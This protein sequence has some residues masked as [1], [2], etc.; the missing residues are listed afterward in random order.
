M[1]N[2]GG[3]IVTSYN[4]DDVEFLIDSFKKHLKDNELTMLCI[5]KKGN[6][7]VCYSE[8]SAMIF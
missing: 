2:D 1:P 5:H 8:T 7:E 4:T 6:K 3:V